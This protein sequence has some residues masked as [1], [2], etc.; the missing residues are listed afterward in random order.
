MCAN[1]RGT[2]SALPSINN[3]YSV[4]PLLICISLYPS[5]PRLFVKPFCICS[6]FLYLKGI[7][8]FVARLCIRR[9]FVELKHV[10]VYAVRL[11]S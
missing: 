10:S 8:E 9:P 4:S 5:L 1:T 3:H 7:C 2:A 11:P 6:T